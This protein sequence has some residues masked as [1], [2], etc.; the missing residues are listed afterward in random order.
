MGEE[1]VANT[2]K[3]IRVLPTERAVLI[4]LLLVGER[5]EGAAPC[6]VETFSAGRWYDALLWFWRVKHCIR[7][8]QQALVSDE[9]AQS[10]ALHC[11]SVCTMSAFRI[12]DLLHGF[13]SQA[14]H[15]ASPLEFIGNLGN[16][17]S[18]HEPGCGSRHVILWRTFVWP[19]RVSW[20]L[21]LCMLGAGTRSLWA[22]SVTMGSS[23]TPHL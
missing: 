6:A 13:A 15:P 12:M 23:P 4:F 17:P 1:Q 2:C 21:C 5:R 19:A 14:R 22:G 11:P 3:R 9:P 7:A 8:P 10:R 18:F 16:S 20:G